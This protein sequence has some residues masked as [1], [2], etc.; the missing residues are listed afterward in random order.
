MHSLTL[1]CRTCGRERLFTGADEAA[2][3]ERAARAGWE[4]QPAPRYLRDALDARCARCVRR[5][6]NRWNRLEDGDER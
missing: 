6:P 3:V 4:V 2:C 5:D 1:R